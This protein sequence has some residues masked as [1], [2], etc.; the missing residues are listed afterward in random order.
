MMRILLVDDEPPAR[1]RMRRL[2]RDVPDVEIVGEAGDGEVALE[3]IADLNP[4]LVLLDVQMPALDGLSVATA[5]GKTGP[6][7]IFVTAFDEF[8]VKAFDVA[9]VDYLLKPVRKERLLDAIHKAKRAHAPASEAASRVLAQMKS[10]PTRIALRDGA[11]YVVFDIARVSAVVAQDHY[12]TVWVDGKEL[13]SDDSLDTWSAKLDP[14]HFIRIHRS[15][16]INLNYVVAL[17]QEGDRK[18]VAVLREPVNLQVPISR[19]R[20]SDLKSRLGIG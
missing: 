5:L 12:A 10:W 13:L 19:E 2:L 8:A 1:E 17:E 11:K 18:Y 15:G 20:L 16:I 3:R 9:A 14:T 7:V 4:D 6:A